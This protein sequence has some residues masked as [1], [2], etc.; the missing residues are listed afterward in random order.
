MVK[1]VCMTFSWLEWRNAGFRLSE[2]VGVCQF[3]FQ[4][5]LVVKKTLC[6]N[7]LTGHYQT[8]LNF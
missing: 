7:F 5:G 1:L 2:T 8:I 6:I 4:T 3:D